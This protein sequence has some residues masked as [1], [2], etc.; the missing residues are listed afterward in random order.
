MSLSF[1]DLIDRDNSITIHHRNIKN[2]STKTF[3]FVQ[4]LSSL[5]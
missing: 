4:V 5:F 1:Q 2:L 3:K